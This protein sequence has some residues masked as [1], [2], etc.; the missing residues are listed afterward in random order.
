MQINSEMWVTETW[1]DP[2]FSANTTQ[3]QEHLSFSKNVEKVHLWIL[4]LI[5]LTEWKWA[6]NCFTALPQPG[7]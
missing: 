5:K 4:K 3:Q 2:G 6:I 7:I 1:D